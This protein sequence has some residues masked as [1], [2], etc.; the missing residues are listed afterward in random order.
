MTKEKS[1][2]RRV[3][4]RMSK[5]GESYA[6]ARGQVSQK[7][8]RVQAAGARLAATADRPSDDKIVEMTGQR[9]E[10]WFATLD[11]WGAR[12]RKHGEIAA[13]LV[14]EHDVPAWWAQTVTVW[15]ERA[16]GIRLKHQQADGFTVSAS[17]T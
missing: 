13:F 3:R 15:Y 2:K 1:F 16:R 11:R 14:E 4:E 9:W 5:T 10:A 8:D 12:E 6:A 7:R 17:K